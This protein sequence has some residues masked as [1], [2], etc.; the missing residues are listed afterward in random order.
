[1]L[2]KHHYT[3]AKA[4]ETDTENLHQGDILDKSE[5]LTA[6][7]RDIHPHYVKDDYTHYQVLTQSCDLELRRGKPKSR[8][9][10][11]AAIRPLKT[12]LERALI[13]QEASPFKLEG[14]YCCAENKK[15]NLTSFLNRLFN[16]NEKELFF[17]KSWPERG[18]LDDSCAFLYLSVALKAE[19]HYEKLLAAK[20]IQLDDN[21][22]SKLGWTVGNLYSRVGTK[23]YVPAAVETAGELNQLVEEALSDNLVFLPQ[24]IY[25]QAK[26]IAATN[27]SID[28]GESEVESAARQVEEK[29]IQSQNTALDRLLTDI[30]KIV[31]LDEGTRVTLRNVLQANSLITRALKQK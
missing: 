3:Y 4:E 11:I 12:A 5:E 9:I 27:N 25:A 23:D 21:F 2:E 29:E 15:Q 13:S 17:L 14:V 19:E 24:P 28:I 31:E 20:Q 18:L 26:K 22:K 30:G 10:T 16:N 8:Y 6:T 1:M 7:L